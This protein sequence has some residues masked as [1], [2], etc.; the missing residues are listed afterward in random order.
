MFQ[1]HNKLVLTI[2][3]TPFYEQIKCI[4]EFIK[5]LVRV[6]TYRKQIIK[7]SLLNKPLY[8]CLLLIQQ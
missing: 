3:I 5:P 6:G 1:L 2:K 8:V 4:L 7:L